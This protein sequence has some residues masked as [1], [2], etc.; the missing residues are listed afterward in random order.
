MVGLGG[1]HIRVEILVRIA[2]LIQ[3][4]LCSATRA[5]TA[6]RELSSY[7]TAPQRNIVSASDVG[8]ALSL[9]QSNG[10]GSRGDFPFR[11][12]IAT[13]H[14]LTTIQPHS[15]IRS[16]LGTSMTLARQ[17]RLLVRVGRGQSTFLN[18]S[19]LRCKSFVSYTPEP[20]S[21]PRTQAPC[22]PS[23]QHAFTL[24]NLGGD[25]LQVHKYSTRSINSNMG[26][27]K[28]VSTAGDTTLSVANDSLT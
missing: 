10:S 3:T 27:V 23:L 25:R 19:P 7:P 22:R 26:G 5:S 1:R 21:C 16:D 4:E 6:Q 28:V 12:G 14:V 24:R 11:T 17:T 2:V 15:Q 13:N 18:P 8:I 9:I 20:S